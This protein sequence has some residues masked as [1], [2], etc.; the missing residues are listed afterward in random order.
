M[1]PASAATIHPSP[2]S[3]F[4]P[5][6]AVILTVALA[7][8]YWWP[9]LSST[10]F[11]LGDGGMFHRVIEAIGSHGPLPA[12]IDW[13][14]HTLPFAYPPLGFWIYAG[15][16]RL[17]VDI[18]TLMH[19]GPFI[20]VLLALT[21]LALY[22]QRRIPDPFTCLLTCA[23]L[24]L[25]PKCFEWT[26][27]GGGVTRAT[28]MALTMAALLC[29]DHL[30]D[31]G[32]WAWR[33]GTGLLVG[34]SLLSHPEW[35][36][37][38]VLLVT[39]VLM[40]R[41]DWRRPLV[42]LPAVGV[43]AAVVML[44][45]LIAII[46]IHGVAPFAAALHNGGFSSAGSSD[47]GFAVNN[48]WTYLFT[49][50][51]PPSIINGYPGSLT[52]NTAYS[53]YILVA[54]FSLLSFFTLAQERN[55]LFFLGLAVFLAPLVTPR[56]SP[57]VVIIVA[58]I[59]CTS[60]L[61]RFMGGG[62]KA[63]LSHAMPRLDADKWS[64]PHIVA[65]CLAIMFTAHQNIHVQPVITALFPMPEDH[66]EMM[67]WMDTHI[68]ED[69]RVFSITDQASWVMAHSSEWLPALTHLHA[70]HLPQ[71]LEWTSKADFAKES[72]WSDSFQRALMNSQDEVFPSTGCDYLVIFYS[73][74]N[75]RLFRTPLPRP[76]GWRVVNETINAVCLKS[77]HD[78]VVGQ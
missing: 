66:L 51:P 53:P 8:I 55:R 45:W 23:L 69:K 10:G 38:A 15:L 73:S 36:F 72:L 70:Q 5:W 39:L 60:S 14:G 77:P 50:A 44:P 71:G 16:H 48:T 27:M 3:S 41:R 64:I 21:S 75:E 47:Q 18:L 2:S 76:R 49:L 63:V 28:G 22:C 20:A 68:D 46:T 30:R 57:S 54:W 61:I 37:T 78:H 40:C 58:T 29:A 35:G 4:R 12:T 19:W 42:D 34:L 1:I 59:T 31:K 52:S 62:V 26:A 17:G 6:H 11:P 7:A 65:T 67:R 74:S 33:V 24:A 32:G 56:H 9:L 25:T 13:N 43:S